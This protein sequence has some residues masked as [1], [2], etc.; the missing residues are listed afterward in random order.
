MRKE[1][2][3]KNQAKSK[4]D[5]KNRTHKIGQGKFLLDLYHKALLLPE[6]ELNN[7]FLDYAVDVTES[8]IGFFHFISDDQKSI[9]LTAWNGQ[10]LKN[11]VAN[12]TSHYPIESAG[13]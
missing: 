9:I 13:R 6:K 4:L 7:Y 8:T 1:S 3:S 2:A 10:A 5:K 12:Y 11:C